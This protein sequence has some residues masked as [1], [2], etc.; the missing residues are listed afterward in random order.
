MLL[1]FADTINDDLSNYDEVFIKEIEKQYL[2][3]KYLINFI[4]IRI[5]FYFLGECLASYH[6]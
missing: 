3:R 2:K 6:R 5:Y 4:F 1:D